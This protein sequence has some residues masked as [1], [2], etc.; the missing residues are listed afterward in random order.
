MNCAYSWTR[1]SSLWRP[2]LI[3]KNMFEEKPN[4]ENFIVPTNDQFHHCFTFWSCQF[5]PKAV[6]MTSYV[7][8]SHIHMLWVL[9]VVWEH[10]YWRLHVGFVNGRP[11][12]KEIFNV[13]LPISGPLVCL[14]GFYLCVKPDNESYILRMMNVIR[15]I[16]SNIYFIR[17]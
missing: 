9:S 7:V 8:T 6:W 4:R 16:H 1:P 15:C 10:C 13:E 3:G 5:P 12:N 2:L 11:D 14:A 17:N